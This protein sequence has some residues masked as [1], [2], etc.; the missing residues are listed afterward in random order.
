MRVVLHIEALRELRE[1]REW[2]AKRGAGEWG[3]RLVRLVDELLAEIARTPESYPRDPRRK[4]DSSSRSR[5]PTG[6]S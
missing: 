3:L 2:Y 5:T 6:L 1:A 4:R